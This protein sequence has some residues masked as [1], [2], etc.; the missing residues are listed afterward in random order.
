[1]TADSVKF[2]SSGIFWSSV[3]TKSAMMLRYRHLGFSCL[4]SVSLSSVSSSLS[5]SAAN[6]WEDM[7]RWK[8]N[9]S[10]ESRKVL[11]NRFLGYF[12]CYTHHRTHH[13][14][15]I[16]RHVPHFIICL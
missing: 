13:L 4:V 8:L 2:D 1:M 5:G 12:I 7:L 15:G 9:H 11:L 10:T 14:W 3:H 16:D 6:C